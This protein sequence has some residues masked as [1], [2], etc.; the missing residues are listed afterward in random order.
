MAPVTVRAAKQRARR[1]AHRPKLHASSSFWIWLCLL[2]FLDRDNLLPAL[3]LAAACH[4]AGHLAML[5][6]NRIPVYEIRLGAGG[7]VIRAALPGGWRELSAV[8][9]GPGV[10]LLLALLTR[11]V[12]PRFCLCNFGLLLYNLLPLDGLD[13]GR[14]AGLLLPKPL[15]AVLQALTL[16]AVIAGGVLGTCVLHLGLW[17]CCLAGFFLLRQPNIP[18]SNARPAGTINRIKHK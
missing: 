11:S 16:G 6:M 7:A 14:L 17:P 18:L 10:N 13:G 1:R 5:A 8:L 12:W 4:E 3:A 9:A 15:C 2:C